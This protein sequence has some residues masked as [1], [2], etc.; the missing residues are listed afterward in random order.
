MH[1]VLVNPITKEIIDCGQSTL[2]QCF[3]ISEALGIID[4]GYYIC[5]VGSEGFYK[6]LNKR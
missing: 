3:D 6:Q 4:C 2:G 5:E 1:N